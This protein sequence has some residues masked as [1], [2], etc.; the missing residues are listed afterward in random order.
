M[1]TSKLHIPSWIFENGFVNEKGDPLT[2]KD[3]FFLVDIYQDLSPEQVIKKCAQIG[4]SVMMN[5]KTF[6]MAHKFG[7]Q[8]IYTMPADSDIWDFVPTKTDKIFQAN[9]EI[10]KH[11]T[12]DSTSLKGLSNGTFLFFKGTRSKTAPISTTADLLIHDETDRSDLNIVEQY[13]SRIGTSKYK[14]IWKLSNP[15]IA[16][17]GVDIE[18]NRS[19]QKE[20]NITCK[21]CKTEQFLI[22][23]ENVDLTKGVY[24]CKSCGKEL[25]DNERRN[26]RWIPKFP[27][28]EI[29]GYH[30]S[31]MMAPWLSAKELIKARDNKGEE[32]FQNFVLGEPYQPGDIENFRQIIYD[33]HTHKSLA[34]GP[35]FLGVD[36]GK[37]KHYVLG[38]KQG[39]FRMG[40]FQDRKEL[41]A[42]IESYKP[43]TVIDGLPERTWAEE[44]RI[45]YSNLYL[46]FFQYEKMKAQKKSVLWGD[47]TV[48]DAKKENQGIV[49]SERNRCI[50]QVIF[51]MMR[52]KILIGVDKEVLERYIK[53]W[54]SMA[55]IIEV[56]KQGRSRFVWVSQSGVNHYCLATV[57]YWIAMRRSGL[58]LSFGP[59]IPERKEVIQATEQGFEMLSLREMM[60]QQELYGDDK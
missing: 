30:I 6:F 25:T 27:G 3:H 24:I 59:E 42:L 18:W 12:K 47:E 29:S 14:G 22:W 23:E 48:S 56:D 31:Q 33:V 58:P 5:L 60:E 45:K 21:K 36:M 1:E 32:Y 44:F 41:E 9:E 4:A 11:L 13:E 52:G 35:F 15:S 16:R 39:I 54:E 28:R 38:S 19:D 40:T 51:D 34:T 7:Y 57:Y 43:V 8:V 37:I 10:R 55:R 20:W 26:G 2:F 53:H 50:D 17:M 46:N 49:W